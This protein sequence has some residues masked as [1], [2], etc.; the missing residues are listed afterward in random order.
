MLTYGEYCNL[1]DDL[2]ALAK[3]YSNGNALVDDVVYDTKYKQ[4]K[5]FELMNP[6]LILP[7][8]PTQNV[9]EEHTDG[10]RKVAHDPNNPMVSITNANGIDAAVEWVAEIHEKYGVAQFELEYK[11]DGASLELR[12]RD[13]LLDDAVTRGQNNI[14]DSVV[15]NAVKIDGVSAKIDQLAD[16][17]IRGEVVWPYDAFDAF[18]D[19]LEAEGEKPMANPRNGAAGSLKLTNP[20]EVATRKL[21]YVAYIVS[22][23]SPNATQSDDIA[24]LASLGFSVPVSN[25][26][27]VSVEGGLDRFRE[28]AEDMRARRS[29]L[30]YA[31]DGI[32]IK[33]NDKSFYETIG[34]TNKAPN[35][36]KAYKF[37]PEEKETELIDIEQS[38][39]PSGAITPVAIVSPVALSGT[40]VSRCSLHNWNLVEYL[41]MFKGCHVVIR[42]AGEIIP[43]L[44]KCSETGMSKDDYDIEKGKNIKWPQYFHRPLSMCLV[45]NKEFYKRPEKCPF[46]GDVLAQAKDGATAWVCSNPDCHAQVVG[47]LCKFVARNVMAIRGVGEAV[48]QNLFDAKKINNPADLYVLTKEDFMECCSCREKQATKLVDSIAKSKNNYLNQL[49]EGLGIPGVGHVAAMAV[50]NV[51]YDY[52]G[53]KGFI[54]VVDTLTVPPVGITTTLWDSLVS[55]VKTHRELLGRL[56]SMG[57][58]QTINR[59]AATSNKL[60]G[61]VCIMTGT[62]DQLARDDFKK[63]VEENG[64]KVCSSITKAC[65]IVLMGDGAGPAKVKK[66]EEL[67]NSGQQI[68]VYTPATL[69]DFLSLLE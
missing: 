9:V 50:A 19:M 69:Q 49:I 32:V 41:G 61:K 38:V 48:I 60:E 24:W 65:N 20:M 47:K 12:Y 43:E 64:G 10:F 5:E 16:V 25:V 62:F 51:M 11:L 59:N 36:Y 23:N 3:A 14:G 4:L 29:E 35:Y 8:S 46:C 37:P 28:V 68:A 21:S 7:E 57:V 18:N 53:M 44:V 63:M 54:D 33:V 52:G 45:S 34:R 30:P 56:V 67:K 2:I 15:S 42:K 58:A 1:V 17:D 40:V 26:V 6:D 39:G 31:I 22:R 27:D 13:G 66:I 55:Y